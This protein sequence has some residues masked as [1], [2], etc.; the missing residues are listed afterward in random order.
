ML[1]APPSVSVAL[2]TY[3]GAPFLRDQL[4]SIARQTRLP[5]EVVIRDDRSSDGTAKIVA[6]WSAR[7]PFPVRWRVNATNLGST[8]NFG[9]AISECAGDLIVLSD[10]DDVWLPHKLERI[11][12]YFAEHPGTEAVFTDGWVVDESL[13]KIKLLSE[14]VPFDA[15][16][17]QREIRDGRIVATLARR[18]LATGATMA[19]RA[20]LRE[21]ILPFPEA[22]PHGL[23]HDAWIAIVAAIRGTLHFLGEPLILY[24]QHPGQQAGLSFGRRKGQPVWNRG[25]NRARLLADSATD[26]VKFLEMLQTRFPEHLTRLR[27]F[28]ERCRHQV[29]RRDLPSVRLG[30]LLPVFRELLSGRYGRHSQGVRTAL[31]DLCG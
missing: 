15:A 29:A 4:D 21:A 9:L 2:C 26:A 8:R 19:L 16:G 28:Q 20:G 11:A 13:T 24:R 10:Q 17:L 7:V 22:L 23:L 12:G 30:R 25:G 18:T 27:P 31:G 5:D 6:D 3:N 14:K 1:N